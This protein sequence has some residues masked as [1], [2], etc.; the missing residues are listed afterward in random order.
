MSEDLAKY[1]RRAGRNLI[2][3]AEVAAAG[4]APTN[5]PPADGPPPP[6]PGRLLL[7]AEAHRE[8]RNDLDVFREFQEAASGNVSLRVTYSRG[9]PDTWE[10]HAA[11]GDGLVG[12]AYSWLS[13][14]TFDRLGL[15]RFMASIPVGKRPWVIVTNWHE[16]E[17][18]IANGEFS[19]AEWIAA[20]NE[21]AAIGH[22]LEIATAAVLMAWTW[23]PRSHRNP[24]AYAD[25]VFVH[26][27]VGFDGYDDRRVQGRIVGGT[28]GPDIFGP[29]LE[30]VREWGLEAWGIRET[31]TGLHGD[32][33]REV[34]WRELWQWAREH[35]AS[36]VAPW[37]SD[38]L[39]PEWALS[40][41]DRTLLGEL[42]SEEMQ[43]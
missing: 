28:R 15:E 24:Q 7:G 17:D 10:D 43:R 9:L 30:T 34:W 12:A 23:D 1:L 21:L 27:M 19:M 36:V 2:K 5:G 38:R 29:P 22:D 14:K 3:A 18:N 42:A 39:E 4:E 20:Q 35:G 13:V 33:P 16:P 41:A 11:F 6:P 25:G 8:G 32:Q 40:T 31:G 37:D 26:P